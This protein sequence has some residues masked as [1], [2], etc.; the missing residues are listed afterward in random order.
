VQFFGKYS[1]YYKASGSDFFLRLTFPKPLRCIQQL[2]CHYKSQGREYYAALLFQKQLRFI[3]QLYCDYQTDGKEYTV[4]LVLNPIRNDRHRKILYRYDTKQFNHNK[5]KFRYD[6]KN[7]IGTKLLFAF[8]RIRRVETKWLWKHSSLGRSGWRIIAR[9]T[10]TG[11]VCEL[12]FIDAENPERLLTK[13]ELPDGDYEIFVLTSSLFWKDCQDRNIRMLAIRNGKE[14]SAFPNIY[15]LR[16]SISQGTTIIEWSA[17]QMETDN[18]RFVLWY[19]PDTS[20]DVTRPPD[21]TIGYAPSQIE[22]HTTF[23]QNATAYITI[24]ARRLGNEPEYGTVHQLFL[25]WCTTPPR[26]PD[27]VIVL[28]SPL[29][30]VDTNID[31]LNQDNPNITLWQ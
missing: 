10:A 14:V 23:Q 21:E 9:N 31:A 1:Y 11:D 6:H 16:S 13:V 20:V 4:R 30:A 24:A 15:N 29:S 28:N 12:G 17:N 27:D 8:D 19:S 2:P 7:I 22:Y 25:D 18:C 5:L 26:T 3:Q